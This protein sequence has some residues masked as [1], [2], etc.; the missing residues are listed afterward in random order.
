MSAFDTAR[1]LRMPGVVI[2]Q[3]YFDPNRLTTRM[4][5]AVKQMLREGKAHGSWGSK[6]K[7]VAVKLAETCKLSLVSS[8]QWGWGVPDRNTYGT[9]QIERV[10]EIMDAAEALDLMHEGQHYS[11]DSLKRFQDRVRERYARDRGIVRGYGTRYR[12]VSR[13]TNIELM[14]QMIDV[15][16]NNRSAQQREDA[17]KVCDMIDRGERIAITIS[18]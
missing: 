12:W 5:N 8:T 4:K 13:G 3:V 6:S 14:H 9:E 16:A 18:M 2:E 10:L 11:G 7:Q 17:E 1:D 15:F